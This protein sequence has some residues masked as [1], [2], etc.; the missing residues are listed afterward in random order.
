M[1]KK[2]TTERLTLMDVF[3]KPVELEF[4]LP[5]G[6]FDEGSEPLKVAER[7][8]GPIDGKANCEHDVEQTAKVDPSILKNL[9]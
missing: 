5:A 8:N 1:P 3:D 7:P 4:D 6:S 2:R 9:E